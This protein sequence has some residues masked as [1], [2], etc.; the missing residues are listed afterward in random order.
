MPDEQI[1]ST[2]LL[3]GLLIL[4]SI[5]VVL[6]IVIWTAVKRNNV[7]S[8][9]DKAL[10]NQSAERPPEHPYLVTLREKKAQIQ[11]TQHD[12]HVADAHAHGH[13]G[14]EEHY[15]EIVGSLGDINDEGCAD[16]DGVRFIEHDKAYEQSD[17]YRDYSDA[18]RIMVWGE[19][20]NNPRFKSPYRRK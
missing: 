6:G 3:I 15:E 11:A 13:K 10:P 14:D 20:L 4:I 19:V 1:M 5:A 16:L 9:S 12:A 7:K 2:V 8:N 17:E 18:V